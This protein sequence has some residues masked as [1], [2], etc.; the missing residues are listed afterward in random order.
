MK[1]ECNLNDVKEIELLPTGTY[2]IRCVKEP[3]VTES[4]TK[5]TPGLCV[6]IVFLDPGTEIAPGVPRVW[7]DFKTTVYKSAE[8]GWNHFKIKE[9]CEAFGVPFDETGFDTDHFVNA[10]AK[11]SVVRETYTDGATVKMRNS[12]DH[13][14]KA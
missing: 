6:P 14:L 5:K 8:L 7:D 4:K 12:I 11:L 9:V 10:E 2:S 13:W 1:I 3:H